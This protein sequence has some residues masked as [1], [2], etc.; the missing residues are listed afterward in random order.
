M[1]VCLC[2]QAMEQKLCGDNDY[3]NLSGTND[4]TSEKISQLE[5]KIEEQKQLRLQDAKQVELKAARIKEWVTNKL[6]ELEFQ[7][8]QLREQNVKCN[9]QLDLLK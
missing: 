6:R 1:F 4:L 5:S 7:N 3:Q 2:V 9:Q 8:Q